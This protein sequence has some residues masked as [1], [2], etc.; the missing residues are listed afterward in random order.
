M[1]TIHLGTEAKSSMQISPN[2]TLHEEQ[3]K[4]KI[5]KK[6]LFF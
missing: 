5:K 1:K 4:A 6:N 2:Q 3:T